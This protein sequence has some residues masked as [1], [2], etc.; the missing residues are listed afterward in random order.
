MNPNGRQISLSLSN[1][2]DNT[3][4]TNKFDSQE[5]NTDLNDSNASSDDL[6]RTSMSDTA[7]ELIL[8]NLKRQSMTPAEILSDPPK[9]QIEEIN[10]NESQ[11]KAVIINPVIEE[12][13]KL[14]QFEPFEFKMPNEIQ[15]FEQHLTQQEKNL[16]QKQSV[17]MELQNS[18]EDMLKNALRR[19]SLFKLKDRLSGKVSR[20]INEIE[21]RKLSPYR[22][23]NSPLKTKKSKESLLNT[24]PSSKR[25]KHFVQKKILTLIFILNF[26]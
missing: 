23:C 21:Q 26:R 5:K 7:N 3:K 20:H 17:Q 2:P 25:Q 18:E 1:L 6:N 24:G 15:N 4:D 22:F 14:I 8:S 19:Q 11:E 12:Q 16:L 9:M 10:K 13:Q